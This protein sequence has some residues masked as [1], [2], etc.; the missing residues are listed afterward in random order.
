MAL[1]L[2]PASGVD[3]I[4]GESGTRARV[5]CVSVVL[6]PNPE[7]SAPIANELPPSVM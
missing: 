5:W 7:Q 4:L 2:T 3:H 6:G 1:T